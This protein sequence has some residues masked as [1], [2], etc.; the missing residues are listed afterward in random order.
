[1]KYKGIIFDFN[2]VLLWDVQWHAE[3][4]IQ[5]AKELGL[6]EFSEE[7][8]QKRVMHRTN[9]EGLEYIL[10][11]ELSDEEAQKL[12]DEKEAKYRKL[13]MTKGYEFAL[14][15]GSIQLFEQLKARNI[16]FTI[17]TASEKGNV[18]FFFQHLELEKWFNKNLVVYD[19]YNLPGKPAPDMY[20]KAAQYLKLKPEECIVVEDSITGVKAANNA[21]I[22]KVIGLGSEQKFKEALESGKVQKVVKDLREFSLEEFE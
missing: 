8:F 10:Q 18:D 22:G 5:T 13:A 4:W 6:R 19:D 11:R 14:S 16:P 7:E 9:K 20:L 15:P 3:I 17:A 1:M 2:G 12:T 21:G